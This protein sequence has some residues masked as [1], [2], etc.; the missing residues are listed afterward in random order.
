MKRERDRSRDV[1]DE[2]EGDID[3]KSDIELDGND[4]LDL[5]LDLQHNNDDFE[6]DK[7]IRIELALQKKFSGP[8]ICQNRC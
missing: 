1:A 3:D 4:Q 6:S 8:Q 7:S 5:D 2:E